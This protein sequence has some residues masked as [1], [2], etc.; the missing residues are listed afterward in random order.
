MAARV[1]IAWCKREREFG[2]IWKFM[3]TRAAGEGL[4]K[5]FQNSLS[6]VCIRLY[7][8]TGK[9]ETQAEG[10]CVGVTPI[11]PPPQMY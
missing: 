9:G 6:S 5:Y 4:H 10:A 8:N 7:I 1:Y 3:W 2:G 11:P